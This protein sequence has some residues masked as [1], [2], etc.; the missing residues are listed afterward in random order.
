M[1]SVETLASKVEGNIRAKPER[2]RVETIRDE[3]NG[4]GIKLMD[5]QAHSSPSG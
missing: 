4:V 5:T 1:N 3:C 2:E